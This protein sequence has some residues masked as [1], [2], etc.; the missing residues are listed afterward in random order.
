MLRE[1]RGGN[2]RG[3]GRQQHY[4]DVQTG[5]VSVRGTGGTA[6][7]VAKR[8]T[9]CLRANRETP[10]QRDA[11]LAADALLNFARENARQLERQARI[12]KRQTDRYTLARGT[13]EHKGL[14]CNNR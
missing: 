6:S 8:A 13:A 11:R 3:F 4:R 5:G 9:R 1:L 7:D 2:P 14:P 12:A 10:E